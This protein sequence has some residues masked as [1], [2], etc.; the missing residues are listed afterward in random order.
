[1]P[2]VP[3][4]RTLRPGVE[5]GRWWGEAG[6]PSDPPPRR[7]HLIGVGL[8]KTGTTTLAALFRPYRWGYEFLFAETVERIV[9]WRAGTLA[10]GDLRAWLG[11]RGEAGGLEMDAASFNHFFVEVLPELYP[12][13]RFLYTWRDPVPWADSFLNMLLRNG[14]RLSGRPWPEWQCSLG[15]LMAPGFSPDAFSSPDAL[16]EATPTLGPELL[17][18][19]RDETRRV[20][21]ALPKE[22][23]LRLA[24]DT[25]SV[26]L[27]TLETFVGLPPGALVA[28]HENVGE[29]KR[30]FVAA[31]PELPG[32]LA[33]LGLESNR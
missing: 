29:G 3:G 15:R 25:L 28:A 5:R 20:E 14:V 13:A 6:F 31:L 33:H 1:M 24:T 23:T 22:R 2:G 7:F 32:L 26:N 12:E 21:A 11:A 30:S 10:E 19:W 18:F 27:G 8:A 9:A 16:A 4:L 17:R